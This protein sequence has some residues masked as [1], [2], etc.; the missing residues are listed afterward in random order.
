MFGMLESLTKTAVSVAVAPVTA[1]V[2]AVMIPIDASEDGE[3][4]QR[5]KSTLNNAAE[6][7]SDAVKPENKK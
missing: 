3:I 5:T 2:D 7:F 4:F 6:N 1:V